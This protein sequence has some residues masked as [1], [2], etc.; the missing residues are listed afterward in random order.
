LRQKSG[1]TIIE[2]LITA[3]ILGMIAVAIFSTFASGLNVYNRVQT[4]GG[5]QSDVLL[6]LEKM[7]KDLRNVFSLKEIDFVGDTKKIA[8]AGLI[9]KFDAEGNQNLSL[10]KISYYFDNE[11]GTLVKEEQSYPE[12]I[13]QEGIGESTFKILAFIED[14]NF[15]FY[16]FNQ[17]AQTYDWKSSW[18][19]GEGIPRGVKIEVRFKDG[20]RDI[21]LARTVLIP[22]S[23]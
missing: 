5:V 22:I 20:K 15:K 10:G 18:T 7:E 1:F 9:K 2:L 12:A 8:F 23:V 13:S 14:I 21:T 19:L 6:S 11:T 3:S 17:E 16:Y 4:F